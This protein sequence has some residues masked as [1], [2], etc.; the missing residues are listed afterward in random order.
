MTITAATAMSTA[1]RMR[2]GRVAAP[3][4]H[5]Q[6]GGRLQSNIRSRS[7]PPRCWSAS[8]S[9]GSI[10]QSPHTSTG[11][12]WEACRWRSHRSTAAP[13]I[14]EVSPR[15]PP[16]ARGPAC[17]RARP[18]PSAR[19]CGSS[20]PDPLA[21]RLR[22]DRLY[23]ALEGI[24]RPWSRSPT[25]SRCS[26]PALERLWDGLDGVLRASAEAASRETG[27]RP[28]LGAAPGRFLT[29]HAARARPGRPLR[30]PRHAG[31]GVPGRSP[32]RVARALRARAPRASTTIC[33]SCSKGSASAACAISP[34]CLPRWCA[35]AS[36]TRVSAPGCSRRGTTRSGSSPGGG[37]GATRDGPR[38]ADRD[39]AGDG[40][41]RAP[42]LDRLLARPGAHRARY[43]SA[44]DW[45]A[46]ARG[47]RAAARAELRP[48][49][50]EMVATPRLIALG[51]PIRSRSSSRR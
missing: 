30:H 40:A 16:P 25:A 43:A 20:P 45:P 4:L 37:T 10:W 48:Q 36:A 5:R 26:T 51:T 34:R 11:S 18:T 31:D 42:G 14:G 32:G 15:R 7:S 22:A 29:T 21:V 8:T 1:T 6:P 23:I 12:R 24:G 13:A 33:C 47:A 9:P 46:A 2:R 39:R 49:L 41:R 3:S 44:R 50:L 38:R 19:P 28:R 35:T 17:A 27:L